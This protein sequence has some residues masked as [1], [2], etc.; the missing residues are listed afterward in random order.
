MAIE[1]PEK[2]GKSFSISGY[3]TAV[4]LTGMKTAALLPS[5]CWTY[6]QLVDISTSL[7]ATV[8]DFDLQV[9]VRECNFCREFC[10]IK[11]SP[12]GSLTI[13]HH[14]RHVL[15]KR[16]FCRNSSSVAKAG[17]SAACSHDPTPTWR[18]NSAFNCRS[19]FMSLHSPLSLVSAK[20]LLSMRSSRAD[21][22]GRFR[23]RRPLKFEPLQSIL[24]V[25][26]VLLL[27]TFTSSPFSYAAKI[28]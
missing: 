25:I 14:R 22:V 27:G 8:H 28:A 23:L 2:P 11:F 12:Y 19:F 15:L 26:P 24:D 21:T 20:F 13:P 5:G 16:N 4:S 17:Y 7:G 9:R 1:K 6:T 10:Q 18:T 3:V